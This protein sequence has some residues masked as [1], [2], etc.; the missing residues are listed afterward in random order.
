MINEFLGYN[1]SNDHY[2][3]VDL[4]LASTPMYINNCNMKF[5]V[6]AHS[7][8]TIFSPLSNL[9]VSSQLVSLII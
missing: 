3:I 2:G 1:S 5:L 4:I 9:H 6:I 7:R 8:F